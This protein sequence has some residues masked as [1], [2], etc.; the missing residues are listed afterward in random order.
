ML[1]KCKLMTMVVCKSSLRMPSSC[2]HKGVFE[3]YNVANYSDIYL[4]MACSI[5]TTFH[6][7]TSSLKRKRAAPM[8]C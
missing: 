5:E 3:K 8:K 1:E 2:N 7:D 6:C 4:R